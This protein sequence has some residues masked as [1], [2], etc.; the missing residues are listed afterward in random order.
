MASTTMIIEDVRPLSFRDC[1]VVIEARASL[2][3]RGRDGRRY[4]IE[5]LDRLGK[6]GCTS[7]ACASKTIIVRLTCS[8]NTPTR[9]P[10]RPEKVIRLPAVCDDGTAVIW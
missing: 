3:A 8:G 10:T 5:F 1:R 2:I 9:T 7:S 4:G 6:P